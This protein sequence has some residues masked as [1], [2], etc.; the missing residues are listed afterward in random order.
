MLHALTGRTL[1]SGLL[2][3]WALWLSVVTITNL[4]DALK[5]LDWI[6]DRAFASGNYPFLVTTTAIYSPPV[7]LNA[8]L[9][10]GVIL[11]EAV[12][13]LLFWVGWW[14]YRRSGNPSEP[15]VMTAFVISSALWVAFTLADELVFAFATENTHRLILVA[16]LATLL[17]LHLV[18]DD[19]LA[20]ESDKPR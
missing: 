6:G 13:S 9:F 15:M 3:G 7:W 5:A 20:R 2:L 8:L 10:G 14:H 19:H 4:T 12:A 18:P 17:T 11:W 16:T 1:K